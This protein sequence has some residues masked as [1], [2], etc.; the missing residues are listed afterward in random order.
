MEP[1]RLT[2]LQKELFTVLTSSSKLKVKLEP[3]PWNRE[4][5]NRA[6]NFATMLA[7]SE[8]E[9]IDQSEVNDWL[10]KFSFYKQGLG[11]EGGCHSRR[12]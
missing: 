6:I 1:D 8:Q 12:Q 9:V 3:P 4:V 5:F 2:S 11:Q 7:D 10:D